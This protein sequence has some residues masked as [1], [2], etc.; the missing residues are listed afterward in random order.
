MLLFGAIFSCGFGV[1]AS[2]DNS[3]RVY[4][5]SAKINYSGCIHCNEGDMSL[6]V[7]VWLTVVL[8][9]G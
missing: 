9:F 5:G 6:S 3:R 8:F 2:T 7:A 1:L 4:V